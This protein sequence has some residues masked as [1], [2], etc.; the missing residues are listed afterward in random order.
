MNKV[1]CTV[2]VATVLGACQAGGIGRPGSPAWEMS[3]TP[4]EKSR[5]YVQQ[6]IS[7]GFA[8][9]TPEM[10]QCR[11]QVAQNL[12]GSASQRAQSVANQMNN[13]TLSGGIAGGGITCTTLENVTRCR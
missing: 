12:S 5:Y 8:L 10:A 1:I 4:D 3:A 7:Y 11:M 13:A 2:L 6:C 9:G